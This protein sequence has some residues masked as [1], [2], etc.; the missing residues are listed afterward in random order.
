MEKFPGCGLVFKEIN[1]EKQVLIIDAVG[2][3]SAIYQYADYAYVGGAFGKGLHNIL[4]AA[5]FG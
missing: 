4:E 1:T 3:L 5:V 2:Y